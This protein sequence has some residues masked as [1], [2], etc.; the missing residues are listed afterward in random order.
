MLVG[1]RGGRVPR[2]LAVVAVATNAAYVLVVGLSLAV[3]ELTPW[4]YGIHAV[5]LLNGAVVTAVTV[6]AVRAYFASHPTRS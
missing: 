4:G 3:S 6:A 5:L 2:W 1:L